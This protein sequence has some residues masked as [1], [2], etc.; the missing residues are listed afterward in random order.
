MHS[1]N[2]NALD[3]A[4]TDDGRVNEEALVD[5]A[6][7]WFYG[8][9]A[10]ARGRRRSEPDN[11]RGAFPFGTYHFEE[12][13]TSATM[14][15]GLAAFD[16]TVSEE[17]SLIGKGSVLDPVITL[18]TVASDA[19]DGDK[20]LPANGPVAIEDAVSYEGLT[21]GQRYGLTCTLYNADTGEPLTDA[22]GK[23]LEATLE[24]TPRETSG[25]QKVRL[26]AS[27]LPEGVSRVV[28]FER[29]TQSG[30]AVACHE[31]LRDA[32]QTLYVP[33]LATTLT[34]GADGDHDAIAQAGACLVDDVSY[35]GLVPG[36]A[37][38]VEGRLV[39][40][41]DGQ[42]LRD[43]RD[44]E[45]MATA[46]LVPTESA[47][48]VSVSFDVDASAL[49]DHQVVATETLLQAER[50]ICSHAD[51]D[52]A[53]QTV[54]VTSRITALPRTGSNGMPLMAVAGAALV[55]F[56]MT[57]RALSLRQHGSL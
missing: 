50:V 38:R 27:S 34:D 31:D 36:Q 46:E 12:L 3:A 28:A 39:D 29:L 4:L 51:L 44:N 7:L 17:A 54:S 43:A 26:D 22:A 20:H 5:G 40:R 49:A 19:S 1:D 8:Y 13:R 15:H 14:G 48:H 11:A 16:V 41:S 35:H 37:Y 33:G 30:Q 18:A 23:A 21:A 57:A 53:D 6:G 32:E 24:F 47:G 55:G 2:V 45:V 56:A 10:D 25:T 42:P 52:D 9:P